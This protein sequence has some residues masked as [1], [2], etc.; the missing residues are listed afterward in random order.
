MSR[1]FSA[2]RPG[3]YTLHVPG[4]AGDGVTD[5]GPAIQNILDT[6]G[7]SDGRH[8]YDVLVEA[9]GDGAVFINSTVQ[10]RSDHTTLRFGSPVVYGALGRMRVSGSLDES[11]SSNRPHLTV[12]AADGATEITVN[13]ASL[14][15]VGDYIVI[16]GARDATG[17]ASGD[18]KEEHTVTDVDLDD[19]VITLGEPLQI[20]FDAF[21]T[22]ALAPA[23]TTNFTEVTKVAATSLTVSPVRNDRTVTVADSSL[24]AAGDYVHILDRVHTTAAS[25][26]MPETGNYK[27]REVAQVKA[28]VNATS[29]RL[30]HGLYHGYDHTNGGRVVKLEPVRHSRICDAS[31]TWSAM[32]TVSNAF[33][34]KYAVQSAISNCEIRGDG[35]RTLSWKSQA[36]RQTDSYMCEVVDCSAVDPA[37][38][39]SGRGYGATLYGATLCEVRGF[40][41]SALRHTVLMFNGA[42]GNLVRGCR[43]EDCAISDYD[44]H[45]A[46]C[47]DNLVTS[48][49]VV[50]GDSAA[51]DGTVNKTA[52]KVGNTTHRDG[53]LYNVF[54]NI[55]IA[56]Y[57]GAAFEV[58]PSSAGNVFRDS[59]VQGAYYGVKIV[60]NSSD[61][62]QL[63][64][65]TVV[66]N[67]DFVDLSTGLLNVNGGAGS[68]IVRGLVIEN[69]RWRRPTSGLIVSYGQR[70]HLRRNSFYEPNM[71]S[72][73]YAVQATSVTSFTAKN[74]D[75]S[76]APRGFKLTS[77]LAARLTG[78]TLHDLTQGTVYEDAGGNDGTLLTRNDLY[79][80]TPAT[81]TS[82]TGPSAGG[83]VDIG[84]AY[85]ADTPGRHSLIEWNYDPIASGSAAGQAATSGTRYLMKITPQVGGLVSNIVMTVGTTAPGTL[86]AAQNLVAIYDST[87]ARI[88]IT[89]DQTTAWA[90]SGI[91]TMALV[92]PVTLQAGKDYYVAIISVASSG[93]GAVFV[94]NS[95]GAVTTPNIGF[96]STSVYRFATNGTSVTDL[97]TSLTLASNSGSGAQPYWV[98]LS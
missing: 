35:A 47:V 53:D 13:D 75:V 87:G 30:S 3:A 85:A 89:G 59:H 17:A 27:H 93:T 29:I 44:I 84:A 4:L 18:Q 8:S 50:G 41:G 38:T 92:T 66:T 42:A 23:G 14:F 80:Y 65:D 28:V 37:D 73:L 60:S 70:I 74:N 72:G 31:V 36:F 15:A 49:V 61:T 91:K 32:S 90:T 19:D 12:D 24:F 82:G 52:C 5:D 95:S 62:T 2:V 16:R 9:A 45:G 78:N 57:K 67:C 71:T 86:T 77:C 20:D 55:L 7:E 79:G 56:N 6:I 83:V 97:P 43:S 98:A 26:G 11:P 54:S 58:V 21:N 81:T 76:G 34:I 64:T 51:D 88:A 48:S 33:E 39:D 22:N 1:G 10:V 94:R 25:T 96:A 68:S 46:E 69:C 63:A 40:R